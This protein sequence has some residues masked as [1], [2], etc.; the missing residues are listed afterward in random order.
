MFPNFHQDGN[1]QKITPAESNP[2][3]FF[4]MF[5]KPEV[6]KLSSGSPSSAVVSLSSFASSPLSYSWCCGGLYY[7]CQL[8][9]LKK[10]SDDLDAVVWTFC[11]L[12]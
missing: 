10:H 7:C 12:G 8:H 1:N 2:T 6:S 3:C 9:H 4:A 11:L 5:R